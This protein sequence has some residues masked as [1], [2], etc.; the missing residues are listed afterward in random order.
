M[1]A[2]S[3]AVHILIFR[4]NVQDY[5]SG[6]YDWRQRRRSKRG[7]T[8]PVVVCVQLC[9]CVLCTL[10]LRMSVLTLRRNSCSAGIGIGALASG[11]STSSYTLIEL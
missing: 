3:S 11:E 9:T 1:R 5:D 2:R 10:H 8:L 7:V 6:L 4:I